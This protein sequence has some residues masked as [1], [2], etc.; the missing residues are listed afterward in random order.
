MSD[1]PPT[2]DEAQGPQP[3]P[4]AY[5]IR[6]LILSILGI[7]PYAYISV[8]GPIHE[9]A[10][11][12][13]LLAGVFAALALLQSR[14][15]RKKLK[16]GLITAHGSKMVDTGKIIAIIILALFLPMGSGEFGC[17]REKARQIAC[18][19]N[20]KNISLAI[21]MYVDDH[22][23]KFPDADRWVEELR[24]YMEAKLLHCPDDKIKGHISYAMNSALSGISETKIADP[25][26]TIL[27]FE[28]SQTGPSPHGGIEAVAK[29]GNHTGGNNFGFTDGH[30]KWFWSDRIDDSPNK[31]TAKQFDPA[32]VSS[33]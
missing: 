15:Y 17:A 4:S 33:P 12:P 19:S 8:Y 14:K 6:V 27:I 11:P 13:A 29:P 25:G 20:V 3:R 1:Q 28:T 30:A 32:R 23:G 31:I 21:L 26:N 22:H 16:Q 7:L 9:A 2:T 24:P 10:M 5:G 18:L